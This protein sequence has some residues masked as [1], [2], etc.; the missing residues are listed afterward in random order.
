MAELCGSNPQLQA[1]A[2]QDL[3][4]YFVVIACRY[5]TD[6]QANLSY[7]ANL[8][9]PELEQLAQD[10]AQ[11]TLVKVWQVVCNKNFKLKKENV[12]FTTY[13]TSILVNEIKAWIRRHRRLTYLRS[14]L[15]DQN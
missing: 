10:F 11:E 5:L 3:G 13:T 6:R 8:A 12:K 9:R 1:Q 15:A 7:I 2:F 14:E 4:W